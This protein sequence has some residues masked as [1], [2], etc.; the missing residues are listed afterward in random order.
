DCV[1]RDSAVIPILGGKTAIQGCAES[2]AETLASMI[3]R[4]RAQKLH[5][6]ITETEQLCSSAVNINI[7][8]AACYVTDAL[9]KIL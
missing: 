8:A 6:V 2:S 1:I 3:T 4:S 7:K 9:S 5:E